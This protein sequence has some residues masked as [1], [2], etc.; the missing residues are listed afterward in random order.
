MQNTNPPARRI[1]GLP[2]TPHAAFRRA[3][4]FT[5]VE[6]LVVIG[7]IAVL[8]GILLPTLSRAQESARAVACESNLRQIATALL[9]YAALNKGWGSLDGVAV[10]PVPA[11]FSR[12]TWGWDWVNGTL[13][14]GGAYYSAG[15]DGFLSPYFKQSKVHSCPSG[16]D[17][18][19]VYPDPMPLISYGSLNNGVK[20]LS[21]IKPAAETVMLADVAV[22]SATTTPP[23]MLTTTTTF[24]KP[25]NRIPMFHGRHRKSGNV[26]WYDGHVTAERPFI[27]MQGIA[28]GYSSAAWYFQQQNLGFLTPLPPNTDQAH[29]KEHVMTDYYFLLDKQKDLNYTLLP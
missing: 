10:K 3:P 9:N 5:L 6:L 11:G 14:S 20:N 18:P 1:Q 22:P 16:L 27:A 12:Y 13:S 26:V 21:Q 23:Y 19:N 17:I 29:W 28:N 15:G 24:N 4:A 8:I 25:S 2:T 7:I